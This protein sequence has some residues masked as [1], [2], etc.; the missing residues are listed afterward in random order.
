MYAFEGLKL[1]RAEVEALCMEHTVVRAIEC[2]ACGDV[3]EVGG[4]HLDETGQCP[5]CGYVGW[6]YVADLDLVTQ[7]MI[8]DGLLARRSRTP[9]KSRLAGQMAACGWEARRGLQRE[10]AGAS[11]R[12]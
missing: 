9:S 7:A 6:S 10:P 1:G 12:I 2:L 4:N 11:G 3:R 5:R 8:V